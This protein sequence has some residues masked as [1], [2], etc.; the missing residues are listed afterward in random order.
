MFCLHRL[1]LCAKEGNGV[2]TGADNGVSSMLV[3]KGG[4]ELVADVELK[5]A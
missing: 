2:L 4:T 1:E 3:G 5:V